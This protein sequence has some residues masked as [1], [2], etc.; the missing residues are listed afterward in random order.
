M[1]EVEDSD[2]DPDTDLG[3]RDHGYFLLSGLPSWIMRSGANIIR[4]GLFVNERELAVF[5]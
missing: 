2:T 5:F 3:C 1:E 4:E